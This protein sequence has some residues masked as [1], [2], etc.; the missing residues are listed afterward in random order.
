MSSLAGVVLRT[1]QLLAS[2]DSIWPAVQVLLDVAFWFS[3]T[4]AALLALLALKIGT[5]VPPGIRWQTRVALLVGLAAVVGL[6]FVMGSATSD[7]LIYVSPGSS[8]PAG[9]ASL[10]ADAFVGLIKVSSGSLIA[11]ATLATLTSNTL[12]EGGPR[13]A[14]P[15]RGEEHGSR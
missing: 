6:A 5:P 7:W 13:P 11:F 1:L 12:P 15:G 9:F 3:M 10:I 8:A 2:G 14:A 4:F